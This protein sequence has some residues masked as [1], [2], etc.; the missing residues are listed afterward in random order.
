MKEIFRMSIPITLIL[1]IL[2]IH[3]C[4]KDQPSPPVITTIM[5]SSITPTTAISGG[6]VTSDGGAAVTS[7]GVCW[8]TTT[9]PTTALSTKTANGTG[10]GIFTS[11]ITGLTP[12][13]TYYLKAYAT[14]SAGTVYGNE[15]VF[16]TKEA[17]GNINDIIRIPGNPNTNFNQKILNGYFVTSI[18]FDSKGNAW[19]GTFDKG[20]IKYNSNETIIYNSSNSL[21]QENKIW[22]IAVDSKDNIWI[23]CKGLI[24][25][26]GNNF[27]LYN[28]QNTPMPED[29]VFS[30][31]IDSKDNIWFT[32]CVFREGGIVKFDGTTW[33]VFTPKNSIMPDNLVHSIAI[34]HND[35]VWLA[36]GGYVERS[37]LVRIS[38]NKWTSYNSD[39]IGFS[40]YYFFNIDIDSHNEVCASIDYTLSNA[41]YNPGPQAFVFNGS[42]SLQ[43]QI[44]SL[45]NFTFLKVDNEDNIWC[46]TGHGFAVYNWDKW[47]IND[48][49]FKSC[50]AFTIEQA[51]DNRIWIGTGEGVF[52]NN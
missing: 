24:K 8:S 7:R 49:I 44:D 32:S 52:I 14:N 21:I 2:L 22:D 39:D 23:G 30:I 40:P 50:G 19:I 28:P 25:F 9:N 45:T 18:A 36:L 20:L 48:S 31:A 38:G 34:D 51:P 29:I 26:D 11:S 47:I 46:N 42:N 16:D 41:F 13:T 17:N 10:K 12:G 15:I 4:K 27:M 33:T 43:L 3:S 5:I 35:N 1:F 37:F 6:N